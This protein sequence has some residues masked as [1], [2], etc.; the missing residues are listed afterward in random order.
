MTRVS[1]QAM[2]RSVMPLAPYVSIRWKSEM[3]PWKKRKRETVKLPSSLTSIL[4]AWPR[5]WEAAP[6][7]SRPR[8]WPGPA[9]FWP[10]ACAVAAGTGRWWTWPGSPHTQTGGRR[11]RLSD[12]KEREEDGACLRR[13]ERYL[14]VQ[15][16]EED[17]EEE[18][19]KP[20]V[21]AGQPGKGLGVSNERQTRTCAKSKELHKHHDLIIMISYF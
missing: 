5:W 3:P 15:T 9:A 6:A 21:G 20:E 1:A 17:H 14:S 7:G 18:D 4:A 19:D 12:G 8:R 16:E 10:P 11:D 2:K 13:W